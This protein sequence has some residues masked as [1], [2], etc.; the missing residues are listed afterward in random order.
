MKR[1]MPV[2]SGSREL[3]AG[4]RRAG[5]EVVICTTRPYLHLSNIEP[6]TAHW[7]RR[8]RIQH[9]GLI[10]GEHKYRQLAREYGKENIVMVLD[11]LPEQMDVALAVGLP[12]VL[13][14]NG[15]NR[16]GAERYESVQNLT[17]AHLLGVQRISDWTWRVK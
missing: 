3:A 7:L 10:M 2:Y 5:A 12:A 16:I 4:L 9:D 6:D 13:R 1:S 11:D 17:E 14:L 15:H 8:N